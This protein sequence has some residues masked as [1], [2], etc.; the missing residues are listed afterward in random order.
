MDYLSSSDSSSDP[1]RSGQR[2][3][4]HHIQFC[5]LN[6]LSHLKGNPIELHSNQK[7]YHIYLKV[8]LKHLWDILKIQ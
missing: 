8:N 2:H 5:T 7:V 3:L 6:A 1:L 4:G